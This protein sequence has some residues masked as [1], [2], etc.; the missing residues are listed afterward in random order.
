VLHKDLTKFT[1]ARL[2]AKLGVNS[3][4]VIVGGPPCRGFSTVRQVDSANHG[5]RVFAME[6]V[7]G[8]QRAAKG[9]FFTSVQ[10]EA[11]APGY[12]GASGER[13]NETVPPQQGLVIFRE[14]KGRRSWPR[15]KACHPL[16][17]RSL[18]WAGICRAFSPSKGG[19]RAAKNCAGIFLRAWV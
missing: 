1:P 11:R 6:N 12:C 18:G 7:L 5:S 16:A 8:I 10:A 2:A 3:V 15:K 13:S 4:D 9:K 14:R 17:A 19:G